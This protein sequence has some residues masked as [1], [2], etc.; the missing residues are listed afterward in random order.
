[1]ATSEQIAMA[2]TLGIDVATYVKA[3][4][5]VQETVSAHKAEAQAHFAE[6]DTAYVITIPKAAAVPTDRTKLNKQGKP[7]KHFESA[8]ADFGVI[9]YKLALADGRMA[10]A[11]AGVYIK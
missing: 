2:K 8:T 5:S 1:M 3:T 4:E 9:G 7:P 6:T 10:F 11:S